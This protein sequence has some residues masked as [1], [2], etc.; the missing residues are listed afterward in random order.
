MYPFFGGNVLEM[1]FN[2]IYL[3]NRKFKGY[4]VVSFCMELLI[5]DLSSPCILHCAVLKMQP[6][7]TLVMSKI[8]RQLCA[9][10]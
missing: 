1:H 3:M 9:F 6:S 5:S 7:K 2:K 8:I 10:I 4:L